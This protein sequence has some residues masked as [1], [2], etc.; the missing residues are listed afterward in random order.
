MPAVSQSQRSAAGA[1]LSAKKGI[2]S[3]SKLGGAAK[4]MYNSM[5]VTQLRHFAGTKTKKLPRHKR[6]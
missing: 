6:G 1:A 5:T 4:Q 3:P 2:I